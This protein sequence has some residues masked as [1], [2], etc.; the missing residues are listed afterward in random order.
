MTCDRRVSR[1]PG[2]ARALVRQVLREGWTLSNGGK[3]PKLTAPSGAV[4][5]LPSSPSD[6]DA[7]HMIVRRIKRILEDLKP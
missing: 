6:T 4:V 7:E 1:I 3:H 5:I 2:R